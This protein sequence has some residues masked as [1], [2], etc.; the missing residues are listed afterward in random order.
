MLI[1]VFPAIYLDY[2]MAR[3][4]SEMDELQ[5]RI[6]LEALAFSPGE[7]RL[8]HLCPGI[9]AILWRDLH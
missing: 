4:I 5:Q 3:L 7:H 2:W 6:Q 1:P 8:N 9:D